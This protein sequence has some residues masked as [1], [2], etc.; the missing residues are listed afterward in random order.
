MMS[1]DLINVG[2]MTTALIFYVSNLNLPFSLF[3]VFIL[4]LA[5]ILFYSGL[6]YIN[7][8]VKVMSVLKKTEERDNELLE[9]YRK[10][11]NQSLFKNSFLS[12][13][14]ALTAFLIAWLGSFNLGPETD[15]KVLFG[16]SL[17]FVIFA[18]IL[19]YLLVIKLP[20]FH[21]SEG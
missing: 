15:I 11:W 10:K 21:G 14:V 6:M 16:G 9:D 7:N 13:L 1:R 17:S 20:E 8:L 19:I 4:V 18:I 3:N 12:F 5:F 2:I